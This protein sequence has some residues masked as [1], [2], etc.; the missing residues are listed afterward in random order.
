MLLL[1]LEGLVIRVRFVLEALV[2]NSRSYPFLK[3]KKECLDALPS[4]DPFTCLFYSKAV[5]SSS[6]D[7]IIF[8]FVSRTANAAAVRQQNSDLNQYT[9][10]MQLA[11]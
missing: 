7:S 9:K 1:C 6:T 11:L 2:V 10:T 4:R 3:C 8:I 5:R